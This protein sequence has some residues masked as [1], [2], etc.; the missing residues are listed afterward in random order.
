MNQAELD[1]IYEGFHDDEAFARES[2]TVLNKQGQLVPMVYGPAQQKLAALIAKLRVKKKPVRVIVEKARQVWLSN[3]IASRF[4]RDTVHRAGQ[5]ALV[6]AQDL[7][8]SENVFSYYNRFEKHYKPF[9]GI[10]QVPRRTNPN[11]SQALE[12]EN[13]SWI[14]FQ[15]AKNLNVGRSH[16][17]RR[18]HLSEFAF[19]GD[20]ARTLMA[21]V[22]AAVPDDPDTEVIIESTCNGVGN[23]F[24][25]MCQAAMAGESGWEFFFFAWWEH[26]EYTRPIEGQFRITEAEQLLQKRYSLTNEQLNWRRWKI[27]TDFAGDEALFDQEYP[28]SPEVGFLSSGRPRFDHK[29]IN[30]M[31]VIRDGL[32]GGLEMNELAGRKK[33]IFLPRE[34]GEL[35]IYT[36][37]QQH[38]DYM[39]GA[40]SAE[41]IDVND[42]KG[43]ADPDYAVAP[44]LDRATGEQVA[45]LRARF[46]PAE[47]GWQLYLLGIYFNWAQQVLEANGAGLAT[48]DAL[49]RHGYP[50]DLLYHRI[51]TPDQDPA[52]RADLVGFKQTLV[53][54]PQMIS[55]VDEAL[56][57]SSVLIHNPNTL[58]ELRTFVIKANGRAEHQFGCH[59]DEVFGLGLAIVGMTQMPR[60]KTPQLKPLSHARLNNYRTRHDDQDERGER[61][62]LL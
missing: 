34:R 17:L 38:R 61:L 4:W 52:E 26:P 39:I 5:H 59:D 1:R 49:L 44:V 11:S 23:E 3:Y 57:E 43:S 15:T 29:A 58:Q 36:K 7:D 14:H 6:L 45:R 12:Y 40:D 30:R 10:I 24:H 31:P 25:S 46:T 41:G 55:L 18:V 50:A 19:Y 56:R 54:R 9:R 2:L 47:F 28:H 27:R 13:E 53:T 35:V 48:I 32:E 62:K 60:K 33:L 51:R 21:A 37:P 8:T 42:G 20:H 22:M 16:V